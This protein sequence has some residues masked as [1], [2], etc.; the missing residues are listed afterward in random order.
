MENKENK[1][2]KTVALFTLRLEVSSISM[3]NK[4]GKNLKNKNR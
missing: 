4:N 2:K 1:K 3:K